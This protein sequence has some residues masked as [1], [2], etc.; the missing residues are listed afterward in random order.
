MSWIVS[1]DHEHEDRRRPRTSA[2][3][4][5]SPVDVF[6]S[7]QRS[8][9]N[10]AIADL[11]AGGILSATEGGGE[12]SLSGELSVADLPRRDRPRERAGEH[13]APA[14]QPALQR[15]LAQS[16]PVTNGVFGIGMIAQNNGPKGTGASGLKGEITFEPAPTAPYTNKL[17]LVQIVKLTDKGGTDVNPA[18][19]PATTAPHVRTKADAA[20]GVE[21]GF[22][23]DVL[24]QNFGVTPP[25]VS[26]KGQPHASYYEGGSPI[27][28]FRR[29]EKAAD[30]KAAKLTDRPGA[31][32]KA[33]LDF[34]FETVAKGDDNQLNYG[35]IHWEFKLRAGLVQDEHVSVSDDAS[36]T[37]EA[38]LGLHE[39]FYVHEPVT[40]YFDF[41]AD[42]PSAG[43]D[44][45]LSAL[46]PY[47][48][49]F[50]D[51]RIKAEG[52]A[53]LRGAADYNR[54]LSRRRA[55]S[56]IDALVAIGVDAGRI[57]PP[58]VSGATSS[59][60]SDAVTAQDE[61]ANRRGN[62][63]VMLTFEHT[64]SIA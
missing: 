64:A 3:P 39:D 47:L 8:V 16:I 15:D 44:V 42:T 38:A 46:L 2:A 20:K 4:P 48:N 12:T 19:L 50:P 41:D 7:L 60:T 57:D 26:P 63:R 1:P 23:T 25:A 31:T 29:S 49:K 5:P 32:G 52:F 33:N 54:R 22:F 43:E 62:R 18:S 56:V 6:T 30:I 21:G 51:V 27:F 58:T 45:K 14:R 36:A 59:F 35:A 24:H 10:K 17:G 9:G 40:I 28:G 55:Q 11:L 13:S 34:T 53:D 61:E 37:Y